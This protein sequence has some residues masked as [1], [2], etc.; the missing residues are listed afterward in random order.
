MLSDGKSLS[1]NV[2]PPHYSP[3]S[4]AVAPSLFSNPL[5]QLPKRALLSSS[6]GGTVAKIN[7]YLG[8]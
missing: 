3:L 6:A 7:P 5:P 2:V 1:H 8:F 4:F